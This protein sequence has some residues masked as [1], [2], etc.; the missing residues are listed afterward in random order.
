MRPSLGA[1]STSRD[2]SVARGFGTLVS[3]LEPLLSPGG[4]VR[5]SDRSKTP[6]ASG[7]ETRRSFCLAAQ[8]QAFEYKARLG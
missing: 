3:H 5:I 8:G 6:L 2:I 4:H 1:S 7:R